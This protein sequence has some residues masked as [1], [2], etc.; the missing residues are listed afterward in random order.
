MAEPAGPDQILDDELVLRRV[1]LRE[2]GPPDNQGR[3]RINSD[4]FI[5]N[6]L[7][8]NVSVYLASETTP[9]A[10]TREYQLHYI[11][12]LEVGE[13]RAVGLDVVRDPKEGDPGHCNIV[14]RKTR[15]TARRLARTARWVAG[16]EP[17]HPESA[18]KMI[19]PQAAGCSMTL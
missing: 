16:Y 4:A 8:G 9:E 7:D 6:G 5:Q 3:T 17:H 10:I 1:N 12:Q 14:G 19:S 13:I 15:G 18:L 11:A 2:T